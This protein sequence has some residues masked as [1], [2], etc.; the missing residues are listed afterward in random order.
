METAEVFEMNLDG[1]IVKNVSEGKAT[2][3]ALKDL[4]EAFGHPSESEDRVTWCGN[5]FLEKYRASLGEE[6]F[7]AMVK[8]GRVVVEP[9]RNEHGCFYQLTIKGKK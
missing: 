7:G 3:V 9:L 2:Q 1:V 8:D 5:G 6:I 4:M